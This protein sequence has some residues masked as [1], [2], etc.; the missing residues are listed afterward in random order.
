M[1]QLTRGL[2]PGTLGPAVPRPEG[3]CTPAAPGMWAACSTWEP[4]LEAPLGTSWVNGKRP[5]PCILHLHL[6]PLTSALLPV[7]HPFLASNSAQSSCWAISGERGAGHW[8]F[9]RGRAV[10]MSVIFASGLMMSHQPENPRALGPLLLLAQPLPAPPPRFGSPDSALDPHSV[11]L[12]RKLGSGRPMDFP[13]SVL[14]PLRQEGK[15]LLWSFLS[16]LR[17]STG[18]P[19]HPEGPC[20]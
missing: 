14:N 10:M 5:T 3:D 11:S 8:L 2:V 18:P 7:H 20:P 19:K 15:V 17:V 13:T 16:F 12:T 6:L 4:E 9:L 1:E